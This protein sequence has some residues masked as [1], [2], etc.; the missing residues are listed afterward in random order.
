MV[1][2]LKRLGSLTLVIA[3]VALLLLMPITSFPLLSRLAGGAEVAPA[4]ILPLG[5]LVLFWFI[6]YLFKKGTIPRE[7]IPFLFFIS[8][9]MIAS[10]A[11]F[12]LGFPPFK[13]ASYS[14][15]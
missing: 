13:N 3:W 12:F 5:W 10:A 1:E 2:R 9:A 11:A 6:P 15:Q 4:S 8:I 7:S 14:S